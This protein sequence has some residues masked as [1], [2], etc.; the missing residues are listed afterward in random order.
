MKHITLGEILPAL[1]LKLD[2]PENALASDLSAF[3]R[4][5][6]MRLKE[7]FVGWEQAAQKLSISLQDALTRN[8]RKNGPLCAVMLCGSD[9]ALLEAIAVE[10]AKGL[11]YVGENEIRVL[12]LADLHNG[13][14][15]AANNQYAQD[16]PLTGPLLRDPHTAMIFSD[17]DH[18]DPDSY[19]AH[20]FLYIMRQSDDSDD[21]HA[22]YSAA[23]VFFLFP[24]TLTEESNIVGFVA[25]PQ[26][27][28]RNVAAPNNARLFA[29]MIFNG[30]IA[31]KGKLICFGA[32][33]ADKTAQLK[34]TIFL[35]TLSDAAERVGYKG[36]INLEETANNEILN[37]LNSTMAWSNMQKAVN[38]I[39]V[40][41]MLENEANSCKIRFTNK[42]F[43]VSHKQV[44]S[45]HHC[46]CQER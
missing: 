9:K 7:K 11:G 3:L 44:A 6:P 33:D 39:I 36:K 27:I 31:D 5:L 42:K 34:E 8:L 40:A 2:V 13:T 21:G 35:P 22:N 28:D 16:D 1:S 19:F 12:S 30:Q 10:A 18:V 37:L 43:A 26:L 4:N 23:P 41:V 24:C 46:N 20:R 38:Q 15:N 29:K 17:L 32:P 25:E 45:L 14:V